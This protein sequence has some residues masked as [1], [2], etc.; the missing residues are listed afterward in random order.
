VIDTTGSGD[1]ARAAGSDM[2]FTT[3]DEITVQGAGLSPK[4]LGDYKQN[5]D[6]MYVDDTDP[7]DVTQVY[8]YGKYKYP[9]A[10]DQ[11]KVIGTRERRRIVGDFVITALDQLNL[12]TYPDSIARS[13]SDFD[14][15]GYTT[16]DFLELYHPKKREAY[17]AY[18]PYRASLPTKLDGILVGALATSSH[19]D[20]LPMMRMQADLQNQ[21][22]ALGY[23]AAKAVKESGGKPVGRRASSTAR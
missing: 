2:S 5:N 4:G 18:Y 14:S 15:H 23:I 8:V 19:R 21:G 13:W 9:S 3:E 6:Y 20:A 22:Y 11:G 12:R 1:I 10:F 7:V 17:Y 16:S